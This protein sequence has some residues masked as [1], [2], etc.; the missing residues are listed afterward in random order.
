MGRLLKWLF[1]GLAGLVTLVVLGILALVIFVDLNSL[2]PEIEAQAADKAGLDLRING[3]L[4]WSFYPYLGI[5]LGA[6]ELRP[7]QTPDAE[8]LASMQGAAVGVAL[9]PLLSGDIQVNLIHLIQPDILLHRDNKGQANWELIQ[10]ATAETEPAEAPEVT[11]APEEETTETAQTTPGSLKLAIADLWLESARVRYLDDTQNLNLEL[12]EVNFRAQDVS[13][14]Q[15]FPIEAAASL[16]LAEPAT[17]LQLNLSSRI[18]IDLVNENYLLDQLKLKLAVGYP[19]MLESPV[20]LGLEGRIAAQLQ[21]G[22]IQLPLLLTLSEPQWVDKTLPEIAATRINMDAQLDLQ[23][24]MYQLQQLA[25]T[26][27]VRLDPGSKMLPLELTMD[28]TANLNTEEVSLKQA[29]MLDQLTQQLDV[30]ASKVLQAPEFSGQLLLDIPELRKLLTDLGV[31]LPEMQDAT[32]L[33]RSALAV[34][35]SGSPEKIILPQL[36]LTFDSTQFKG[37]AGVEL[38]SQ[39]IFLRMA[40]D[41]LDA[42]RYL[43]PPSE[44]EEQPTTAESTSE[45]NELL[46]VEL[47][48]QL[49][50]DLGFTLQDFKINQLKMQKI[51]LA[52]LAKNGL[53]QLERANLDLYQGQFRNRASVDVRTEPAKLNFNTRLT[54]LKLRPL[55]DDLELQ[56][57]PLRGVMNLNGDFRTT[58]T[59]LSEWLAGSNGKGSLRM[60]NGAVTG[61]NISREVCVAAASLDG[62]SSQQNWSPDTEFTSLLADIDLVNGKLNNRDLRIAVKGFEISGLGH[63]HLVN[64]DFLYNL[65]IRFTTDADQHACPVS[66][67]LAL[68]RWPVECKGSLAG[69]V[70]DLRCRP[71]TKAVTGLV[72]D[73]LRDAAKREAEQLKRQAEARAQQEAEKL[74]A[75]LEARAQQEAEAAKQRAE[76]EARKRLEGQARDRLKSLF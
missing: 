75:E 47:L 35:F 25:L 10:P 17:S 11:P 36:D 76:E 20:T 32:T 62:R 56:S 55:L 48:K 43:P 57:V 37:Q 63:Y 9:L 52:V 38:D 39:A 34:R 40:G 7:L 31:Q 67:N 45:D 15:P 2:K 59:R 19:A 33:N 29:L 72:G 30:T 1:A 4:S 13:L 73:L 26:S 66:E 49:N 27:G 70:P 16:T 60:V 3:E 51:D 69:E 28:A 5:R 22:K 58:G 74:R 24:Q 23:Q 42:D 64:E 41:A 53:V 8:P 46:P 61:M 21:Q 12:S 54:D 68:V 6:V 65:G 14:D 44:V 18:S 71:D 50:L